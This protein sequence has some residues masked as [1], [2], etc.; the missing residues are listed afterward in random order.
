MV[1]L[2][3]TPRFVFVRMEQPDLK[4]HLLKESFPGV[5]WAVDLKG[6]TATASWTHRNADHV[7]SIV[8]QKIVL[9]VKYKDFPQPMVLD[10]PRETPKEVYAQVKKIYR[11]C[12][13]DASHVVHQTPFTYD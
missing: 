3:F 12:Y 5:H 4:L 8:A 2:F 1:F 7:I 11:I 9:S 13:P 10:V 6:A